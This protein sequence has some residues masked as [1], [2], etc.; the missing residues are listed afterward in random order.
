MRV[1]KVSIR[2]AST[3][4]AD[5]VSDLF[6]R[7]YPVLMAGA[8]STETLAAALP[9]MTNANP[10]LLS[11]GTYYVAERDDGTVVGCGGFTADQPGTGQRKA[12][13]G[14]VRHFAT[15]PRCL[16]QGIGRG[17]IER[18]MMDARD[19]GMRRLDCFSS[20]NAVPFYSALG[21]TVLEPILV[22][23]TAQV[24]LPAA[25]MHREI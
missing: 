18:A 23:L 20:L 22:P 17:I 24:L 3:A 15:D 4:D 19:A 8:Y 7:C 2:V 10:A 13:T 11:S 21:F 9:L 25:H 16:R 1:N 12:A 6:A 14:H 5:A